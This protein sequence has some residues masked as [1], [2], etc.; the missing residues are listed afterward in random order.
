[1]EGGEEADC[2]R[3]GGQ[4]EQGAARQGVEGA[5]G[6]EEARRGGQEDREVRRC[7]AVRLPLRGAQADTPFLALHRE[8][9]DDKEAEAER[10]KQ[11]TKERREREA[12]KKRL[13]EMAARVRAALLDC[14]MER[15]TM[16]TFFR[17]CVD[18]R[19]EAAAVRSPSTRS[20]HS[21]SLTFPRP[22]QHEEAHGPQQEGQR[23]EGLAVLWLLPRL[24]RSFAML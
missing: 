16:L 10:K 1:M 23:L 3:S 24:Y 2:A 12:E 18:E 11:I 15:Q 22:P 19:E 6:P 7:T 13:E 9:K 8:I 4:E 21:V 5:R 14:L 20:A 17:P